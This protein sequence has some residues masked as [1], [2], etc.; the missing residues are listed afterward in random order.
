MLF[1][2]LISACARSD[3]EQIPTSEKFLGV[4]HY[5]QLKPRAYRDQPFDYMPSGDSSYARGYQAGCQSM[6]SAL[7]ESLYRLRGPKIDPEQL[8][9]DPWY[10]R[11]YEDGAQICTFNL[12]WETH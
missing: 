1:C 9:E 12:D 4:I 5:N 7:G 3:R 2:M 6:S 11:G 10:L 8:T